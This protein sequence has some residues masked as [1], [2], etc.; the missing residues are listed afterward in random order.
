MKYKYKYT[1]IYTYKSQTT[2]Y[3]VSQVVLGHHLSREIYKYKYKY[4]ITSC[5][6][7]YTSEI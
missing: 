3:P 2:T 4:R 1:Y 5:P 6:K 7:R